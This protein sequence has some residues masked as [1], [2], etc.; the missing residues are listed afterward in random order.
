MLNKFR[1]FTISI[2][3]LTLTSV[4]VCAQADSTVFEGVPYIDPLPQ[5]KGMAVSYEFNTENGYGF[6]SGVRMP[7]DTGQK[8]SVLNNSVDFTIAPKINDSFILR[9]GAAWD[10]YSISKEGAIPLPNT[11]QAAYLKIGFDTI[12]NN[13]WIL[14]VEAHPGLYSDFADISSDDFQVQGIIGAS[15]LMSE[16]FQWFFGAGLGMFREIPIFPAVGFRWK[17]ADS[18][19]LNAM[20]PKPRLTYELDRHW[21]FFVGGN[22][23]GG[24]FRTG[25]KFG[26]ENGNGRLNSAVLDYIEGRVGLGVKYK[27]NPAVSIEAEGGYTIYQSFDYIRGDQKIKGDPAPYVGLS[28]SA[29]F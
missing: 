19:T 5:K 7:N 6:S 1:F 17:F 21:D 20:L 13:E 23:L 25:E 8:L 16:K 28:I 29:Q 3:S 22:L 2:L 15:Y 4:W 27:I 9:F 24:T 26:E 11:L 10:R 12:I 14:R 18:W